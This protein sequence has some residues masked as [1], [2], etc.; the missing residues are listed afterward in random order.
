MPLP[1]PWFER[2]LAPVA[3]TAPDDHL[4]AWVKEVAMVEICAE[5]AA[6]TRVT[7]FADKPCSH[8]VKASMLTIDRKTQGG[9]E[10]AY[11]ELQPLL[12]S[13]CIQHSQLSLAQMLGGD[14][15]VVVEALLR[16]P[17]RRWAY[18]ILYWC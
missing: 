1:G 14:I 2:G 5:L 11:L 12:A 3:C 10:L 7:V 8:S 18:F 15:L 6:A 13:G 9:L 4:P 17:W 16:A